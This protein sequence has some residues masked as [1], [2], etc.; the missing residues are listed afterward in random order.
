M[1]ADAGTQRDKVGQGGSER[2]ICVHLCQSAVI[3]SS[4]FA[5]IRVNSRPFVVSFSVLWDGIVNSD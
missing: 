2:I 3:P 4:L 1:E 5:F